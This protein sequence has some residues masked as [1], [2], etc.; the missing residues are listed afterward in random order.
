MFSSIKDLIFPV[1]TYSVSWCL[2]VMD[3]Q[4]NLLSAA[5]T[6]QNGGPGPKHLTIQVQTQRQQA[7][8]D[9]GVQEME[10]SSQAKGAMQHTRQTDVV[11]SKKISG[12]YSKQ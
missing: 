4:A 5:Q 8:T 1:Q 10:I 3:L 12:F 7:T 2:T 9:R 11:G 6:A